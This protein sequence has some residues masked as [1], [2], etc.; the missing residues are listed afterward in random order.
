[1]GSFPEMYNDPSGLGRAAEIKLVKEATQ[2]L[3]LFLTIKL[4]YQP[5]LGFATAELRLFIIFL[6]ILVMNIFS[7]LT[8]CLRTG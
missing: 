3:L 2:I 8:S 7:I 5:T 1:M 6:P 4:S